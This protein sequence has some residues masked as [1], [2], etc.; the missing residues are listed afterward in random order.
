MKKESLFTDLTNTKNSLLQ[1]ARN[2]S[3]NSIS[4]NCL[5][6]LSEIPNV[7]HDAEIQRKIRVKEN[8]VKKPVELIKLIPDLEILYP[9]L[10]D[11]NLLIYKAEKNLTIIDIR[12]FSRN[13]LELDYRKTVEGSPSMLHSKVAFPP[14]YNDGEKIDINWETG[15][16]KHR[17]NMFKLKFKLVSLTR[18]MN[19]KMKL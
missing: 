14:Y 13:S 19:K 12:Y 5:F 7:L 16:L 9:T 18:E 4:D 8:R 1:M 3:Y 6:I 15:N 17:W 11:I 10:H 2:V